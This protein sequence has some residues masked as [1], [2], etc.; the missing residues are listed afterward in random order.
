MS[1]QQA[2]RHR[3]FAAGLFFLLLGLAVAGTASRYPIGTAMRMG[4]GY[5]PM[6]LGAILALLGLGIAIKALRANHALEGLRME[7]PEASSR[8]DDFRRCAVLRRR[9]KGPVWPY[10][11]Y[12]NA[13]CHSINPLVRKEVRF[14][15]VKDF[16][17]IAHLAQGP[18]LST[19]NRAGKI[20]PLAIT[21]KQRSPLV[22]EAKI[23][24]E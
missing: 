10:T 13:S 21:S 12:I 16:T 17:P 23:P 6:L 4:P 7:S 19:V 1:F 3:D 18:P 5:F 22:R 14:D 8:L 24:A 9:P 11:L 15:A 2:V 20:R